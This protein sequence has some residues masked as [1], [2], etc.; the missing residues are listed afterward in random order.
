[1]NARWLMCAWL[2][3][4]S[5]ALAAPAAA[6]AE[7]VVQTK[8]AAAARGPVVSMRHVGARTRPVAAPATRV[9]VASYGHRRSGRSLAVHFRH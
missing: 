5:F 6:Q 2:A 4:A 9:A 3:L 1:M 7:A 8:G